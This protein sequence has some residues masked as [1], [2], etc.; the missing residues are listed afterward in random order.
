MR[1][2]RTFFSL[3][4]LTLALAIASA[5]A[6]MAVENRCIPEPYDWAY[7]D[8]SLS[9][10]INRVSD[11]SVTYFVADVQ[12][13]SV[14][15]FRT[16]IDR[17]LTTVST[18]ADRAG[19]VLAVNGDDFST[20]KYGVII[21][22]GELLRAHDTTRHMLLV[23]ANG[24]MSVRLDRANEDP[25]KLSAHLMED[26]AWQSFEFGPALVE[27]GQALPF[28]SAFNVISLKPS[29]REPR[30][31]IGQIGPLHYILIVV[32]GRQ[33]GYSVGMSLQDL[34]QLML[35]YGAQ[36]ALNLDGGRSAEIWF[37]GDILNRPAGGQERRVSD[38]LCF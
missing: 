9:I 3:L 33:D 34:Q 18:L 37:Q 22:N 29:R 10:A 14:A 21:R 13:S 8:V 12:L 11:G 20:H 28:T 6:A 31:A 15:Q 23:D 25:E 32:D 7:D 1:K 26:G 36:T 38:I 30:T 4:V 16:K 17:D 5:A 2:Q 35:A 27:N 19:A 24:D